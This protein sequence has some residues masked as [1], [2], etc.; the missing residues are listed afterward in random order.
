MTQKSLNIGCG[1]DILK[2]SVNLDIYPFPGVDIVHDIHKRWPFE[3][4]AF[5]QILAHHVLEH[6][7]DL[8][9]VLNEAHRCLM[10][11]GVISIKVPW[12]LGEWARGDPSHVRFFDH[13]SFSPFSDW[14][15]DYKHLGIS[16]P[17]HKISQEYIHRP[18][19]DNTKFLQFMGFSTC[20]EM[21][22]ILQRR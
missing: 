18:V 7:K 16:G 14:W 3:T 6:C 13:N 17:W 11:S 20:R 2:D 4:G 8:I 22:T 12:C 5:D 1:K 10:V 15:Q 19:D 9:F 21:F